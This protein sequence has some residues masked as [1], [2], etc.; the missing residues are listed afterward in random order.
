MIIVAKAIEKNGNDR[1][2]LYCG[3]ILFHYNN[4]DMKRMDANAAQK[5]EDKLL[6]N[7]LTK[8]NI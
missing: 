3:N 5:L 2:A 6:N 7:M 8:L 1:N 4:G